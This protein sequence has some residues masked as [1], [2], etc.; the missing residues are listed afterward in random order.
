MRSAATPVTWTLQSCPV[1]GSMPLASK[2]TTVWRVAP[3][4]VVPRDVRM[5]ILSSSIT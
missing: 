1:V 5:T 2:A 3:F 4:T